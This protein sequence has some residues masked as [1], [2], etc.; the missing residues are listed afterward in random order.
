MKQLGKIAFALAAALIASTTWAKSYKLTLKSDNTKHGTVSGGGKYS[1]GKRVTIKASAKKGYVFAGWYSDEA[2][3]K[4]DEHLIYKG[5]Y[6]DPKVTVEIP[7]YSS[8]L[9]A[10]F[11]TVAKDKKS[12]KLTGLKKYETEAYV[13][14]YESFGSLLTGAKSA[15]RATLTFKNLPKGLELL[16]NDILEGRP[17]RPGKYTVRATLTSAAGNSITQKF[18]IYVKAPKWATRTFNGAVSISGKVMEAY[19]N[20][21]S[22]SYGLVSGTLL[23]RTNSYPFKTSLSYCSDKK[24]KFSPTITMG[25]KTYKMGTVVSRPLELSNGTVIGVADTSSGNWIAQTTANLLKKGGTLDFLLDKTYAFDHTVP[26]SGL[27][28]GDELHFDFYLGNVGDVVEVSGTANGKKLRP[29]AVPLIIVSATGDNSYGFEI[30]IA[31]ALT[32]YYKRMVLKA[33]RDG[34]V[35]WEFIPDYVFE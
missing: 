24:S 18:K 1:E 28:K 16:G 25:R 19:V 21:S 34:T 4:R 27:R 10:K 17:R 8:T 23:Y 29:V 6:Q 20:Y 9:Y 2:C 31:S 33:D 35:N 26:N 30:I 13:G 11:I 14:T 15:S 3:K 22:D 5:H 12:L 32:K 7:D